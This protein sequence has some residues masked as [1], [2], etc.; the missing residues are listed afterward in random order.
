MKFQFVLT[1][2]T[3]ACFQ[4]FGQI[5]IQWE[6]RYNGVGNFIDKAFDLTLD[7]LGNTYVTGATYSGSSY[8][9]ATVKYD[10]DGVEQWVATYGGSGIDEAKAIVLNSEGD[11]IVTGSRFIGGTDWD[12]V[13]IKY[14][15]DT[16]AE[17]WAQIETG[18]GRFDTGKDLVVDGS[19]NIIV[20]GSITPAVGNV[21]FF[22]IKYDT[23][24]TEIWSNSFGGSGSDNAKI[25]RIDSDENLYVGGDYEYDV[26]D[27]FFDYAV[28]K[29]DS[30][31]VLIWSKTED[32]G[33]G[34]L[35]TPFAMALTS[36]NDVILGGS[37]FTDILN[38]EDY[39]T[40]KF[41]GAT[42]DVLWKK[43]YAGDA[44][45]LDV[46][47]AVAVDGSDNVIVTG[48]SK[49]VATSED[50]YTIAYDTDGT[51][52]WAHRYTTM[53]LKYDE[54]K[55]VRISPS[56]GYVYVTGYSFYSA[57]N[58]DFA[59]LKYDIT[60]GALEWSTIFNG[61]ASNSD[62]ALKMRLDIDDN[63]FIT[64]NS[65][66]GATNLD[67]STIK[68]CQ[69][70]TTASVDTAI[71]EGES[72]V[73][74][75]TGG[76]N[77][78]WSV[79]S[80][81]E[82]SMSC[83][84]CETMTATPDE[85][86]V[87]VVSSESVAGCIDYDTVT[88][89]VNANPVLE[90]YADTP[91]E[92]CVGN[93]VILYTDEYDEY[94][95]STGSDEISTEVTETMTVTLSVVD[96]NLCDAETSVDVIV[97]ELPI[98]SAGLD[99]GVCPDGSVELMASGATDYLWNEDMTLS[100]LD[101]NNPI[102]SPDVDKTYIVTGTDDSGC[103]NSDTVNVVVYDLPVVNAGSD[104]T[105]CLGDSVHLMASGAL[106]YM[107]DSDPSLTALDIFD[108]WA[109]PT[110][111]TEYFVT[112]TDENGCQNLDSVNVATLAMPDIDAGVDTAVCDGSSVVLF[113]T[114]G[115]AD[116][117]QWEPDPSLSELD[118]Y[119]PTATPIVETMYYVEGTDI[120]G[121]K[122]R[123][124]VFVAINALPSV[125]AGPDEFL[126]LGDSVQLLASG[127][128]EYTWDSDPSLSDLSI[129]DPWAFPISDKVYTVTASDGFGC[130]GSD[131]VAVNIVEAPPIDAGLDTEICFGDSTQLNATGGV[132]YIWEYDP[133]LSNF[134]IGDPWATP[135]ET[136]V[137]IVEG[138]DE[139][140]CV[141]TDEVT[142][143]VHPT[144]APPMLTVDSVFIISSY[145]TGNQWYLDEELLIDE[146]N[147]TVN[148]VEVGENGEY[149][150][151]YTDEFGCSVTSDRIENPI[152]ITDVSIKEEGLSLAVNVYPNPTRS[153][154]H[155]EVAEQIDRVSVF[156]FDGKIIMDRANVPAGVLDFDMNSLDPATYLIRLV[157]GNA[158]VL[159]QV[160]KL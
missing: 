32:S 93:S 4:G 31:G 130:E 23:D 7:D 119:N 55:D 105:I 26:E 59:T 18:T 54:A 75:A 37:G 134:V 21:D 104:E 33:F 122:N 152:L 71:C 22:T 58:N 79:M 61:P 50:F 82:E 83:D 66:G 155:I 159:K 62:Q 141:N 15:G 132:I 143:T 120:N 96:E 133:T 53:G 115:L 123:D 94:L 144:P 67:F 110:G 92:F 138:T 100:D 78:T 41:S 88:V 36:S 128:L 63:I 87:Y 158:V 140:G 98:V 70:T 84:V 153:V 80:G 129:A 125:D 157:K 27:T 109:I 108:P 43:F 68:Y 28:V 112:G 137:Y 89:T 12:M 150:V 47:N 9:W 139:Y 64:G 148:Y 149:W 91:L 6:A 111:F 118:V 95:W 24:G 49:S 76:D 131:E 99:T 121:C 52:L 57:S 145:E 34:K 3:L 35:D 44:E 102:A 124:S 86:T 146:T 65:H 11:V 114:G 46:I 29:Y 74:E 40:I 107:W 116:L 14:D 154:V 56:G 39:L 69:L 106:E 117:Y 16:G 135:T 90:I 77:V 38:E 10:A 142:V 72:V 127:G 85:S 30:D 42:G 2:M 103:E 73:L 19:D 5:N 113:A 97:Y 156:S 17:L 51:E 13:T 160:I 136:T 147:D 101:V 25:I 48:K 20:V 126:C 151:L 60:D 81:D 1:L 45:A 8:D